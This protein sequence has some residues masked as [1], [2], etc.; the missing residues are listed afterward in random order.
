MTLF[1]RKYSPA[2]LMRG[3]WQRTGA[4]IY[5]NMGVTRFS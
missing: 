3:A 4:R 1:V 5:L 2:K